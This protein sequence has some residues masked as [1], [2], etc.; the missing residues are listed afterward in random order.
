MAARYAILP[1][2]GRPCRTN[3][4][5]SGACTWRYGCV[6]QDGGAAIPQAEPEP[7]TDRLRVGCSEST[8]SAPDGSSLLTSD[9]SSVQTAPDGYR[10]IVWMIIGMIKA[11][12]MKNRMAR[13]ATRGNQPHV[14]GLDEVC[15]F[16]AGLAGLIGVGRVRPRARTG[17]RP[18]LGLHRLVFD[19]SDLAVRRT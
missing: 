3:R 19:L 14:R 4:L 7:S 11:H 18:R 6:S 13:R 5:N 9:A 16:R 17:G 8:W 10:P 15:Q 1:S 2:P 12:L